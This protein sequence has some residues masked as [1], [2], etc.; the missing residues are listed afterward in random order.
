MTHSKDIFTNRVWFKFVIFDL[1]GCI[2]DTVKNAVESHQKSFEKHGLNI[3]TNDIEKCLGPNAEKTL[4]NLGKINTDILN[5]LNDEIKL[6][7]IL[8]TNRQYINNTNSEIFPTAYH[9]INQLKRDNTKI[10][11]LTSRRRDDAVETL[12]KHNILSFFDEDLIIGADYHQK[13]SAI[14]IHELMKKA[15]IDDQTSTVY[16]GDRPEDLEAAKN[17]GISFFASCWAKTCYFEKNNGAI[18][19]R[20]IFDCWLF[21]LI[22]SIAKNLDIVSEKVRR[23]RLS[24]FVGA[25]FSLEAGFDNWDDLVSSI[26]NSDSLKH[27]IPKGALTDIIGHYSRVHGENGKL[28]LKHTLRDKFEHPKKPLRKHICLSSLCLERIW[29]TNFDGLIEASFPQNQY[30]L[31]SEDKNLIPVESSTQIIKINGSAITTFTD[32]VLS[33]TDFHKLFENRKEILRELRNEFS[34]KSFLFL[35]CSFEDPLSE[36]LKRKQFNSAS[37]RGFT[38]RHFTFCPSNGKNNSENKPLNLPYGVE[39]IFVPDWSAIEGAL[40][41]LAWRNRPR[42]AVI[43]GALDPTDA[44]DKEKEILFNLGKMLVMS[45]FIIRHGNGPI[46]G[47]YVSMGAKEAC[48]LIDNKMHRSY[49]YR[50]NRVLS[51]ED[52]LDENG[53]LTNNGKGRL[54]NLLAPYGSSVFVESNELATDSFNNDKHVRRYA[55]M[56]EELFDGADICIAIGGVADPILSKEKNGEYQN[57]KNEGTQIEYRISQRKKIPFLP[58]PL[59][60]GFAKDFYNQSRTYGFEEYHPTCRYFLEKIHDHSDSSYISCILS[61]AAAMT[62]CTLD[63][64]IF[65]NN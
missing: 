15:N 18:R 56:R 49:I 14:G 22:S 32:I 19:L 16:I 2:V 46:V 47:E 9:L 43:S 59:I 42:I 55:K 53:I 52:F 30:E 17:A 41:E 65:P 50:F 12:S 13:P 8:V 36:W 48:D 35:G 60:R 1:D 34:S 58:L 54:S 38:P 10:G 63:F 37:K 3:S 4:K 62:L 5:L 6:N 44:T 7:E 57:D 24:A 33:T 64:N 11:L 51:F 31:I 26:I 39:Q 21:G 20:S 23:N 29:T 28:K 61:L 27:K 45:N 40:T 25:G